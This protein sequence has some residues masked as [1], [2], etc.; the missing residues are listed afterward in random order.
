VIL[1]VGLTGGTASGKSSVAAM[2]ERLGC[3]VV[4]ADRI[5]AELYRPGEA[6]HDALVATYGSEILR[7][8]G[9]VDRER[10]ASIAFSSEAEAQ[11]LNALIHPL[12]I[13]R[14]AALSRG[15]EGI[16]VVEAT[17]LLESGGR[18]RYDRIVVVDID[19]ET[20]LARAEARGMTREEAMRRIRFQ[21]PREERL[22]VADYVIDNSGDRER[23][24]GQ[25]R[26]THE[27]LLSDLAEKKKRAG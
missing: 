27:R 11:R 2:F 13:A 26:R 19:P 4:D 17:L 22:R 25:V 18:E 12:V 5:V 16:F 24:A 23:T 6:G 9:E 3:R 14:E 20:Q 1:R 10:L 21:M 7:A 8:D 15:I